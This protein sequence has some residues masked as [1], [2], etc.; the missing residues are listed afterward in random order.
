MDRKSKFFICNKCK[1]LMLNYQF[2]GNIPT[3]CHEKM[4]NMN[5]KSED[6]GKEKHSP[7]VKVDG[8]RVIVTVGETPHPMTDDHGISWIYLVTKFGDAR[9]YLLPGDEPTATFTI[10]KGDIPIA[11]YAHCNLHSIWK[12]IINHGDD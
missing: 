4:E 12:T 9:K 1:N 3:C 5:P 11:A 10:E 6:D 8:E 7:I 2:S